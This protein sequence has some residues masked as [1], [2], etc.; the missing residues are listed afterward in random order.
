MLADASGQGLRLHTPVPGAKSRRA[1]ADGRADLLQSSMSGLLRAILNRTQRIDGVLMLGR[2]EGK[3]R[4][5]PGLI[6]DVMV[7]AWERARFRALELNDKLPRIPSQLLDINAAHYVL[8][9]SYEPPELH[10]DSASAEA[11][12]IGKFIA[13]I[14]PDGATIELGIGR[15]LAGVTAAL[16]HNH[17]NLA[18]HT[19]IVGD[20]A[21]Q[22]IESGCVSRPIRGEAMAVGATAMGSRQYYSWVD[23]NRYVCLVDSRLAHQADVL[24]ANPKFCAI[25]SGIEVD[26]SGNVNSIVHRGRTIGGI[27]GG[28]D[29]AR[30]GAQGAASI[31]GLFATRHDGTSTIVGKAQG[32]SVPGQDVTHV[33]TE[34]G[35]AGIRG[36]R[37]KDRAR[38][39]ASVAA[40]EHRQ[41]LIQFSST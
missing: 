7:P 10:S 32:V 18:M 2:A 24:S 25:N 41:E 29:F 31:I 28:A 5:T 26:L 34:Y 15:A 33:V 14:I 19:G 12:T 20:S 22:L 35:I 1:I 13:E 23:R 39:I 37:G 4:A 11:Y 8:N 30:G 36:L 27:G 6:A 9:T 17:R 38:V 16:L 40:P 21:M 3:K